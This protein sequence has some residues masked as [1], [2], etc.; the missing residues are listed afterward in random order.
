MT[1]DRISIEARREEDARRAARRTMVFTILSDAS[2]ADYAK[3][4][5]YGVEARREITRRA[6]G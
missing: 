5:R 3:T 4:A 2:L 6:R 1:Y